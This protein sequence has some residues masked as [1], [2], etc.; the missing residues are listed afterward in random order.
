MK[1][2]KP[3]F[4]L[5]CIVILTTVVDFWGCKKDPNTT[6]IIPV[7]TNQPEE[8]DTL[9]TMVRVVGNVFHNPIAGAEVFLFR[10]DEDGNSILAD[11]RYSDED[12]YCHWSQDDEIKEICVQ[13]EGYI[14][15]CDGGA[16]LSIYDLFQGFMYRKTAYAWLKF[17]VVDDEPLNPEIEVIGYI[18]SLDGPPYNRYTSPDESSA[19][20]TWMGDIP[21]ELHLYHISD[22][23][24]PPI[25]SID[26]VITVPAFDTLEF[27]YH[28]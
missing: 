6:E 1:H 20:I 26:T 17:T 2:P 11:H 3:S 13:Q 9:P 19:L 15:V 18:A 16:Y 27:V 28:Y 5:I 8:S 10:T 12:G 4:V 23:D 25:Y 24:D 22:F 7:I 14:G 21:R